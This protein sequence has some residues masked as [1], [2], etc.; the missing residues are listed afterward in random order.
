MSTTSC[1]PG[2][3]VSWRVGHD[4][5]RLVCY[6]RSVVAELQQLFTDSL[7]QARLMHLREW[8]TRPVMVGRCDKVARLTTPL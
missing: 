2:T 7:R 4:E 6:E 8:Q 5:D 3:G 1:A